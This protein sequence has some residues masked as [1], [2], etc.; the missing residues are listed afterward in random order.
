MIAH[1]LTTLESCDRVIRL[2]QGSVVA[3][4]PPRI[5]L[6]AQANSNLVA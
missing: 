6:A 1:R 5:V 2:E 3:D 4:G